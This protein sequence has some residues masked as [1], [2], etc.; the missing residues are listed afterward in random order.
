MSEQ[1]ILLLIISGGRW[2]TAPGRCF[3][4]ASTCSDAPLTRDVCKQP[5]AASAQQ[6]D[7]DPGRVMLCPTSASPLWGLALP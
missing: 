4:R 6:R 2:R 7:A 3:G 1:T 5:E